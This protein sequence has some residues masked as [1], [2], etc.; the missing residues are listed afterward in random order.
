M[1][2]IFSLSKRL[3][4][5]LFV[6]GAF[7]GFSAKAATIPGIGLPGPVSKTNL[8]ISEL[9][10]TYRFDQ[11]NSQG[12]AQQ[13]IPV[14]M[15]FRV[16]NAGKSETVKIAIPVG[17]VDGRWAELA[18]IYV[19]G[20]ELPLPKLTDVSLPDAD[21]MRAATFNL[22]VFDNAD[23]IVDIRLN[24]PQSTVGY[25][26]RLGTGAN[27]NG[28]LTGSL[29]ALFPY[30]AQNWNTVLRKTNNDEMIPVAYSG[31]SVTWN[32][33]NLRP[34]TENDAYWILAD[35]ASMEYFD[36]GTKLYTETRGNLESYE[37]MLNAL[38]DMVPC[39]DVRMPM[40]PWWT[41]T[42]QTVATGIISLQPNESL[43]LSKALELWSANWTAA[44]GQD[45]A[46]I[47][48]RQSPDRYRSVLRQIM[49]MPNDQRSSELQNALELHAKFLKN[50]S[51]TLGGN[52]LASTTSTQELLSASILDKVSPQ[53]KTILANWDDR[54]AGSASSKNAASSSVNSAFK[55]SKTWQI[56]IYSIL[57]LLVLIGIAIIATRWKEEDPRTA[58]DVPRTTSEGDQSS[59]L[60]MKIKSDEKKDFQ[61]LMTPWQRDTNEELRVKSEADAKEKALGTRNL[62]L[63]TIGRQE[64]HK[65]EQPIDDTANQNLIKPQTPE[66]KKN[67]PDEFKFL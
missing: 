5:A 48:M 50:L 62:E 66:P 54:F 14:Q 39:N 44:N 46:C 16:H 34:A 27:W 4:I 57:A 30:N 23:A 19:N 17:A 26:F 6:V 61:S 53:D 15:T 47:E 9:R 67:E 12:K 41:N 45:K 52:S 33:S 11:Q 40:A 63:G 28:S 65:I 21:G 51:A 10:I 1:Q 8:E 13:A 35:P 55:L 43:Q 59:D 36:R 56:V 60:F 25:A 3:L 38:L 49:A 32:F 20:K 31:H 2:S 64:E 18:A 42:H 7:A 58:Y 24:Q 37:M 22:T 29:E